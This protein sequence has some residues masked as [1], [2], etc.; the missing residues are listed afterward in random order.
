MTKITDRLRDKDQVVLQAI[1]NS[2]DDIQKITETTT[3][4][5]HEANYCF[6]KLANLDLI[7]VEKPDGYTTR[8][9]NGQ[10]RVFQT[11]KQ[12]EITQKGIEILE[13]EPRQD[14]DEYEN[15]T[16]RE[17]VENVHQLEEQIEELERKLEVFR[18]QVKD[19]V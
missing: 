14:L 8:R 9:I 16:H 15:L 18:N 17:L 4:E 12:A 11:P 13:Q 10:K 1:S 2:H 3:L 6:T 5:N 7:H 19:L